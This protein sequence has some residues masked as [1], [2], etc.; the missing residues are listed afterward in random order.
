MGAHCSA[1]AGPDRERH[2]E[3]ILPAAGGILLETEIP[4]REIEIPRRKISCIP[5]QAMVKE[6]AE[7]KA[8]AEDVADAH[9]AIRGRCTP[10]PPQ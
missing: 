9:E 4:R 2:T 7:Y 8:T 5:W 3:P 10:H 6:A 1:L